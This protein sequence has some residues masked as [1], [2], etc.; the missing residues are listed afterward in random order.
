[1]SS[2]LELIARRRRA[3]AS[4]R[5]GP[6][7]DSGLD[8]PTPTVNGVASPDAVNGVEHDVVNGVEH[9][10]NGSG[11]I[12][13]ANGASHRE[14]VERASAAFDSSEVVTQVHVLPPAGA[15][16]PRLVWP[17]HGGEIAEAHGAALEAP[18]PEAPAP[19]PPPKLHRPLITPP[20]LYES[21]LPPDHE[22]FMA[23]IPAPVA[24]PE[25]E[26]NAE[27]DDLVEPEQ[28]VEPDDLVEPEQLVEPDEPVE[29][30]QLVEPDEPVEP[31]QVVAP[32]EPID[33]VEVPA[34]PVPGF[35][36]RGR[37]RRRARYLRQLR[38]VQI[39]DIGGFQLELH[40]FDAARPDVLQAKIENAAQTDGELRALERALDDEVP[41]RE[42]REPGIGGACAECGAVHGSEDRFC[43]S[44]GQPLG[45]QHPA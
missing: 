9:A 26:E 39:R 30:E 1:M 22:D 27:P 43:A 24:E 16:L 10:F 4:R 45:S 29:P 42:L 28:L 23:S 18:A 40:R 17:P 19:E 14:P 21:W 44:C 13:G 8:A 31:E 36:E 7:S 15:Q 5:L 37:M 35:V 11:Q 32:E 2:L 25:P 6:P 12:N 33:S 41:L 38:E 34:E 3:S 20:P